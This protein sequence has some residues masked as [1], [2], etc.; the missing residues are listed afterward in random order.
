MK[1][2][3]IFTI[4]VILKIIKSTI[5]IEKTLILYDDELILDTHSDFISLIKGKIMKKVIKT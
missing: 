2:L 5:L 3:S 4:L 1:F